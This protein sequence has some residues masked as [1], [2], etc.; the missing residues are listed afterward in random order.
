MNSKSNTAACI[1][2]WNLEY[3]HEGCACMTT[4]K[5]GEFNHICVVLLL[6]VSCNLNYYRQQNVICAC[7]DIGQKNLN[8]KKSPFASYTERQSLVGRISSSA[9]QL[10]KLCEGPSQASL[11]ALALSP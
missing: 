4:V 6:E 1:I 3:V 9:G 10:Q 5:P 7:H 11:E 2:S 8:K